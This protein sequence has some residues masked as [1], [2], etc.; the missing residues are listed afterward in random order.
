MF[1]N[2]GGERGGCSVLTPHLLFSRQ[3]GEVKKGPAYKQMGVAIYQETIAI[4][5]HGM[6]VRSDMV[7][8]CSLSVMF[9]FGACIVTLWTFKK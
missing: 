9:Y 2:A 8:Q 5:R 1:A 3:K 7:S 4:A 6:W